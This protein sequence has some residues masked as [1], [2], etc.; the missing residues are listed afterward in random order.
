[1]RRFPAIADRICVQEGVKD[2]CAIY[3]AQI[4]R[5][6]RFTY[7]EKLVKM[8]IIAAFTYSFDDFMKSSG[9]VLIIEWSADHKV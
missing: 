4:M 5:I 8:I 9:G 2:Y 1:M 7:G 6:N 3:R